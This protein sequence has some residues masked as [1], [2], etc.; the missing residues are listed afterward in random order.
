MLDLSDRRGCDHWD[1][2]HY[3][4][5]FSP[6]VDEVTDERFCHQHAGPLAWSDR[7][8]NLYSAALRIGAYTGMAVPI[9]VPGV[10]D[11]EERVA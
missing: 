1:G 5:D 2:G 8:V 3:C 9:P 7:L 4:G 6:H 11:S 10:N